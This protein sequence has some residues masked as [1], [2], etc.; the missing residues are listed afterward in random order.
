MPG[1][2]SQGPRAPRSI[3][4][5]AASPELDAPAV[6]DAL[7]G[8]P[9]STSRSH[10]HTLQPQIRGRSQM[11][12]WQCTRKPLPNVGGAALWLDTGSMRADVL[13]ASGNH[14]LPEIQRCA[15]ELCP[16]HG[17]TNSHRGRW[18]RE[19]TSS[20]K[21][22]DET[23]PQ[24]KDHFIPVSTGWRAGGSNPGSFRSFRF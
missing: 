21:L 14:V 5:P 15:P 10:Q 8:T 16:A 20:G 23:A 2:A 3:H 24:P 12:R 11:T 6:E 4:L 22:S 19:T 1:V 9:L 13:H 18:L 17:M 7:A